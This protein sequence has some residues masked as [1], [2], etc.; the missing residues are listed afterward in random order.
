MNSKQQGQVALIRERLHSSS[1]P[2]GIVTMALPFYR[3]YSGQLMH[4][5]RSALLHKL[6][7]GE[8]RTHHISVHFWCGNCGR[9]TP[10]RLE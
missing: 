5:V 4:R 7:D 10:L 1:R 9:K 3:S 8:D 6:G 2:A